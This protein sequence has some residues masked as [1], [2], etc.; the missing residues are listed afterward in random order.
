MSTWF[1]TNPEWGPLGD[2]PGIYVDAFNSSS[3]LEEHYGYDLSEAFASLDL[4]LTW[5][6]TART[7][8]MDWSANGGSESDIWTSSAMF[9]ASTSEREERIHADGGLWDAE[10][11]AYVPGDWNPTFA[12]DSYSLIPE[13]A[14]IALL[15]LGGLA[16]LR[17][18]I[19]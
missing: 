4:T 17:R 14:T 12:L 18:R 2:R 16:L 3:E 13:P 15:G 10:L 6:D 8:T 9:D 19:R 11:E 1:N 7:F 5:D